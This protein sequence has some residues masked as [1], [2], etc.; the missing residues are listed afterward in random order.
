MF[1]VKIISHFIFIFLFLFYIYIINNY[2]YFYRS[3]SNFLI[4]I[5]LT[6]FTSNLYS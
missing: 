1:I 5:I 4:Y 3:F 6:Y 2:I